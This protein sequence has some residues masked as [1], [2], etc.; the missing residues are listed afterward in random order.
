MST[1]RALQVRGSRVFEFVDRTVVEPGPGQVRL[2]V[3]A[4]GI[5]HSDLVAVEG[6]REDPSLPIVPGHE[7]V[8]VIDAVGDGVRRWQVGQRVGAGF[9]GGPC[10]EC[11][12]CRRGDFVNCLDQP[13]TG[14]TVDGG[15]AQVA[16]VR[17]SGLVRIPD[18]LS[19]TDAAPLLCAGITT[20]NA[21]QHLDLRPGALV[22]IQGI[23]GLGHLGIQHADKL[24]YRVAA[25]A[26][27]N[28]KETLAKSFGA[29]HYIDSETDD[30]AEALQ[31]LGGADAIVATAAKG[32]AMSPLVAGLAPRG[33][34]IVVGA[35]F[36][37]LSVSTIELVFGG[38]E[39]RGSLTGTPIQNED[40]LA[41]SASQGVKPMT[42]IVALA[43]APA[44]Y[45]RM[46]AGAVRFRAVIDLN[47]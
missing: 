20:F 22:A 9:L 18:A 8:G 12:M 5:C 29:D 47:A 4:C 46:I 26:R 42:E 36:D 24:G 31:K 2:R 1:Y 40:N 35:A 38:R 32:S 27:G 7:V 44:A 23:G 13:Q 45:D 30:V 14:T 39:I 15:Y 41:F 16:Y 6:H 19:A 33:R 3:E 10:N 43:D 34:L 17:A 21:L 37:P 25:V 28:A 11:A